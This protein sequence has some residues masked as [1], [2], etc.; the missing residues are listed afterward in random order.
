MIMGFMW[1]TVGLIAGLSVLGA[2]ELHRRLCVDWRGWT[3]LG[4]GE[5]LLLFCIAWSVAAMAEGEPRAASM[6]LMLFGGG[7]V[8]VLALSWRLFVAPSPRRGEG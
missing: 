8:A 6:G 4:L 2:V 5:L 1:F 7:G 3:G